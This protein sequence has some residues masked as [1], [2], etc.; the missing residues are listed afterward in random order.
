MIQA[1][2]VSLIYRKGGRSFEA[3]KR[4][5]MHIG[6]GE[7]IAIAGPSGNGKSSLLYLLSALRLPTMGTVIYKGNEYHRLSAAGLADLR[8]REFG[9]V[10]Q[11][12]SLIP[13]LTAFENIMIA[14][15]SVPWWHRRKTANLRDRVLEIMERLHI[16]GLAGRLP[17][18]LSGGQRHRVAIARGLINNPSA[19]F[20]DEPT[21]SL[22]PELANVVGELLREYCRSGSTVILAT[23]DRHLQDWA[24][25]V[26][27][28][29]KGV[30]QEG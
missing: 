8:R 30:V 6:Q 18:E 9:L 7:M 11:H 17:H 27:T 5:S 20:A 19:V 24:D 23:H 4:A 1:I 14:A 12:H 16:S 28:V 10:F 25:R 15:H 29:R 2:E 21:A 13:H 26:V 22:D 3:V